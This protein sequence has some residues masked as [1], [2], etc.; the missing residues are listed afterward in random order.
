MK[1]HQKLTLRKATIQMLTTQTMTVVAGGMSANPLCTKS[2]CH[3]TRQ[4]GIIMGCE[5]S[6]FVVCG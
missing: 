4:T 3:G 6:D 1:N 5:N 2:T